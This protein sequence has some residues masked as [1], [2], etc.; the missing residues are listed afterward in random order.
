LRFT[1]R[2]NFRVSYRN[3]HVCGA[4][5]FEEPPYS[6][7]YQRD[8]DIY[9]LLV[10]VMH[11]QTASPFLFPDFSHSRHPPQHWHESAD[12]PFEVVYTKHFIS[13]CEITQ[14]LDQALA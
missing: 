11:L 9:M 14:T 7:S 1:L 10:L 8:A 13:L 3:I 2:L 5:S 6:C 4:T 12:V